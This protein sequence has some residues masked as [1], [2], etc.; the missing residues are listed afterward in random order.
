MIF[1]YERA[2]S[3]FPVGF[4]PYQH[5]ALA[6]FER[7]LMMGNRVTD[8]VLHSAPV[9]DDFEKNAYDRNNKHDHEAR[10]RACRSCFSDEQV[11]Q[12]VAPR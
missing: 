1:D 10:N 5:L 9:I 7:T 8:R 6:V 3:F 2:R 11:D 12:L 4:I